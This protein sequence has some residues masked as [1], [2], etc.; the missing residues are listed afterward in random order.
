MKI[1]FIICISI[2]I[3]ALIYKIIVNEIIPLYKDRKAKK[4][5]NTTEVVIEEEI[6]DN[7]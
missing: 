7:D 3:L 5:N 4:D 6:K 2:L 1:V